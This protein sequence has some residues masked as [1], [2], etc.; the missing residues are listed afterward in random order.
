MLS[1]PTTSSPRARSVL[2]S[3]LPT[4]PAAPVTNIRINAP[5]PSLLDD[6]PS[7]LFRGKSVSLE[8]IGGHAGPGAQF[9]IGSTKS[10]SMRPVLK[11]MKLKRHV[12]LMASHREEQTV[13]HR[14]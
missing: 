14:H 2:E 13:L 4:N 8:P 11:N 9:A 7:D 3:L 6:A 1:K 12:V 5:D 10:K